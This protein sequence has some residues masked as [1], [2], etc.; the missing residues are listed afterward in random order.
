MLLISN[1]PYTLLHTRARSADDEDVSAKRREPGKG[2]VL[3]AIP[4]ERL[5]HTERMSKKMVK[6]CIVMGSKGKRGSEYEREIL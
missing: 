2:G 5:L 4:L 3:Y 1:P 6:G